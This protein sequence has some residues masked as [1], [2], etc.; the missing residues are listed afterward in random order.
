MPADLIQV[1]DEVMPGED[2][3]PGLFEDVDLTKTPA[4]ESDRLGVPTGV[5]QGG[6]L[7]DESLAF[8]V[9]V[10]GLVVGSR[11]A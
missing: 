7:Q 3:Q 4:D 6:P 2:E 11:P 5:A 9:A 10:S 1:A 8:P